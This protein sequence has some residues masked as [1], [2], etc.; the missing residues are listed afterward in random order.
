MAQGREGS[1][2]L[3]VDF[4]SFHPLVALGGARL[5]V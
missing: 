1:D 3:V 5:T 2:G 4:F